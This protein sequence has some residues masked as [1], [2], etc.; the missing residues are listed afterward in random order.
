M[1][2]T[3]VCLHA[4]SLLTVLA[5]ASLARAEPHW[6]IGQRSEETRFTD[7][8]FGAQLDGHHGFGFAPGVTLGIPLLDGGFIPPINDSVFL[9]PGLFVSMRFHDHDHGPGNDDD[10]DDFWV[11]VIPEIGPRWNFHLTPNWDAFAT[12]KAGVA[13][14][15]DTDFWL[16]GTAG[17]NWW[18]ARPWALRLETSA[19]HPIGP[20]GYIGLTFQ[21]S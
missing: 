6:I 1:N 4:L 10:D 17:M 16:R 3:R 8:S 20:S 21:F 12:L 13:I 2:W 11:W 15:P 9:E 7:L 5:G 14:G 19:G 18:F